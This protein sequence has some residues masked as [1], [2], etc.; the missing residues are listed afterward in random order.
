MSFSLKSYFTLP[1]LISETAIADNHTT[2]TD[3]AASAN[4]T[5][6]IDN[7]PAVTCFIPTNAAFAEP[8]STSSYDTTASLLLSHIIPDFIGYLPSLTN[9]ATFT[10]QGGTNITVSVKGGNFY[11]NNAKIIA[12][13]LIVDNGVCHVLDSVRSNLLSLLSLEKET[14]LI[15]IW[16]IT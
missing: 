10:T 13:N 12:S 16:E 4:L 9:G 14:E 2:F 6:T 8:N 3:L 5:S 7:T 15:Y 11:I 1:A